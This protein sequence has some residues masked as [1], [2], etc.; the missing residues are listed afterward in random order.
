MS[1]V[2]VILLAFANKP[3]G[4]NT[5]HLRQLPA[6][7]REVQKVL[8]EAEGK[9]LCEAKFLPHATVNDIWDAFTQTEFGPRIAIFHYS[10]HADSYS[11]L[12]EAA[13][14]SN[15]EASGQGLADF[16]ASRGNLELIFL[17]ACSTQK[18]AEELIARGINGVIATSRS[19]KDSIAA[20]FS[21]RFY[22]QIAQG[23]PLM[24]AFNDAK[25]EAE[26]LLDSSHNEFRRLNFVR[27]GMADLFA[28]EFQIRSGAEPLQDWNLPDQVGNPFFNLPELSMGIGVPE[29]PFPNLHRYTRDDAR[30]FF[31][32]GYEIRDLFI[33][34]SDPQSPSVILLYGAS[35]VGKSSLLD[36]GLLPRLE[37][38]Q[39]VVYQ[40]RNANIGLLPMLDQVIPGILREND[41]WKSK[42]SV[43]GRP[44]SVILDQVEEVFTRPNPQDPDEAQAL[45]A[46]L[47]KMF[48][49]TH[50]RPVGKLILSMRKEYLPEWESLLRRHNVAY[51][52]VFIQPLEKQGIFEAI[53]GI[54][55]TDT[56]Q[57]HYHL[58][59]EK[60]LPEEIA[61]D[62]L[63]NAEDPVIAPTLQIMLYKLWGEAVKL[64]ADVP[65]FSR[66]LYRTLKNDGLLLSDFLDHQLGEL[67][68]NGHDLG[69]VLDLLQYHTTS[70][71][72]SNEHNYT[73]IKERYKHVWSQVENL[74]VNLENRYLLTRVEQPIKKGRT[75]LTTKL[76]H[77]TLASLIIHR[78]NESDAAGQRAHRVLESRLQG[79]NSSESL[80]NYV[81]DS[82]DLDQVQA[83]VTNMRALNDRETELLWRSKRAVKKQ[84]LLRNAVVGVFLILALI[85]VIEGL[86]AVKQYRDLEKS[87]VSRDSLDNAL[88]EKQKLNIEAEKNLSRSN[89]LIH[90]KE[91]ERS[92]LDNQLAKSKFQTLLAKRQFQANQAAA[93]TLRYLQ[94][95]NKYAAIQTAMSA[96]D[97]APDEPA[98]W[99]ALL[100]SVYHKAPI[101]LP[102]Q[103]V[104]YSLS[105]GRSRINGDSVVFKGTLLSLIDLEGNLIFEHDFHALIR[106][107]AFVEGCL[108]RLYVKLQNSSEQ[109]MVYELSQY[110]VKEGQIQDMIVNPKSAQVIWG[111]REGKIDMLYAPYLKP[112]IQTLKIPGKEELRSLAL[113]PSGAYYLYTTALGMIVYQA[114]IGQSITSLKSDEVGKS[115]Q[116]GRFAPISSSL[117][118]AIQ[119]QGTVSVWNWRININ[120]PINKLIIPGTQNVTMQD[121]L[122]SPDEKW[123][124]AADNK[125]DIWFWEWQKNPDLASAHFSMGKAIQRL[126]F[127]PDGQWLA[128]ATATNDLY[129]YPWSSH[130]N[131][132]DERRFKTIPHRGVVNDITFFQSK[133]GELYMATAS[134]DQMVRYFIFSNRSFQ[135][136]WEFDTDA[137]VRKV[138]FSSS[139][140]ELIVVN[141][142]GLLTPFTLNPEMILDSLQLKHIIP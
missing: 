100:T 127:S 92:Q 142:N 25:S 93:E 65:L 101:F 131:S 14:K 69:L 139:G 22:Q 6:E 33:R 2:P 56:L 84:H 24:R 26:T 13:E 47:N 42:E 35:G 38:V 44:V 82:K 110:L 27:K 62:L 32:R 18:H 138:A 119:N 1:Q 48:C 89:K 11:L 96:Y 107:A 30:I 52:K 15:Q 78:Y 9:G 12:L 123:V 7:M 57:R 116:G 20:G 141:K 50:Q 97:A 87:I 63:R 73:D 29:I 41:S 79:L 133:Q 90:Q 59:I 95:D 86:V 55:D 121:A 45:A 17:N 85:T 125:G 115:F 67:E 122:F 43:A 75:Q 103:A 60:N 113:S 66:S 23:M 40:R 70:F 118:V 31:G 21:I 136:L 58:E 128:I 99:S 129:L 61:N 117:V 68:S 91:A 109:I 39:T 94:E 16:L 19:V 102:F 71:G 124:I 34:I 140:D 81:L 105:P 111:T 3:E 126:E 8:W 77:D 132:F 53:K 46:A 83:G 76:I 5:G 49:D 106:D 112:D 10:G 4:S 72:T 54:Y 51:S 104:K 135:K 120:E 130:F 114:E 98:T 64:N 137:L 80:K 108:D 36:A 88:I 37:E 28:W 74:L 134:S